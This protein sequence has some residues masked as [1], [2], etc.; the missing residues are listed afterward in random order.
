MA[1]VADSKEVCQGA[2]RVVM[3]KLI[4]PMLATLVDEPFSDRD[5]LFETKWDGVRA[6]CFIRNGKA[7][8]ISRNQIEMTAQYP[9][10]ADIVQS[11]R[12]SSVILDG[13]IVALDEN[14][15]SRFQL[16]QRRLGRKNA[17]DIQR[18]AATTRIAFYVFDLL[19]LDGFDLMGCKLF[20]RKAVLEGILK[21]SKNIRY[22]DHIIGEGEK[23]FE[24]VAKVPLEGMIAKRLESTYAQRRSVEWLK[25]KTIQLSEVVIGGHT[26]PRNS[27]EYFGAL[28]VGLYRDGKLHY[29]AHTGGGFNHQTLAQT[30]KL[31]QPLKTRD[32]PFVD[33]PKTNEPVQWVKPRL[34]AQVKFS[35]WTADGRMRHPVFLGLR[36]DKKPKECVFEIKRDTDQVLTKGARKTKAS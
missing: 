8:F 32:C 17:G 13:E 33:K 21:S 20:N 18:L 34:V 22:S 3:P 26:E 12:G 9:E 4:N 5:W 2:K 28:V 27:R 16:L 24:E 6:V 25:I 14:G 1:K 23:L 10:L 35:E 31:M 11:I 29:V 30:Y 7:R 36:Q 19:Y 15:V